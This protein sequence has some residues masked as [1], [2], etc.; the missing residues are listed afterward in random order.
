M[1]EIIFFFQIHYLLFKKY[2]KKK[3]NLLISIV[4]NFLLTLR[5]SNKTSSNFLKQIIK[6]I[7]FYILIRTASRSA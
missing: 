1:I 2:Q 7:I 4:N 3:L 5:L 6:F